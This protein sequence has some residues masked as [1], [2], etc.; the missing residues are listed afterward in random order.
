MAMVD[1]APASHVA[2]DPPVFW[3]VLPVTATFTT[4]IHAAPPQP[5]S[6][7]GVAL[8]GGTGV[9]VA[10]VVFCGGLVG[11]GVEVAAGALVLVRVGVAVA[12][13]VDVLVRVATEVG[14]AAPPPEE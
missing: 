4:S 13:N 2:G 1:A 8:A 5:A 7:V 14:V 11:L 3:M 12:V 9:R 6:T 10:V